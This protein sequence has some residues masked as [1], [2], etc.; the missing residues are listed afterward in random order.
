MDFDKKGHSFM[1]LL[2]KSDLTTTVRERKEEIKHGF[3]I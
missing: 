1:L 3:Q 2:S